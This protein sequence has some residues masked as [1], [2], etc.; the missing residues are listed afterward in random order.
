MTT[1]S[2]ESGSKSW[3][4]RGNEAFKQ[5]KFE[6]AETYYRRALE[7][8]NN[9][10]LHIVY[11]NL[12]AVYFEL[13][14]FNE[15]INAAEEAIALDPT[16]LKAYFRKAS[17]LEALPNPDLQASYSV[18]LE[19]SRQCPNTPFLRKNLMATKEKW[20][21]VFRDV[22]VS[23]SSDLMERYSLLTDSRAR[24]S[25]MAHFWN[26][27]SKAERFQHFQQFMAII[28]GAGKAP[29]LKVTEDMMVDMPLHN[30]HDLPRSQIEPWCEYF[31][32]CEPNEKTHIFKEIWDKIN[33]VE[34]TAVI[35][36]L[37]LF[38]GAQMQQQQSN[39]KE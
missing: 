25:T 26:A 13:N 4:E 31:E 30:Y 11:S 17:A 28:S 32:S 22:P 36:D 1:E 16:W 10:S 23:S 37:K 39:G 18:W 38:L 3:K 34:Q 33:S 2:T 20:K 5:K 8:E 6:E 15:C 14:K 27:S 19:A 7:A 9:D 29:E 21:K 24:L 12:A 35:S